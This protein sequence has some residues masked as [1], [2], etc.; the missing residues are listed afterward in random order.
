MYV[1]I[2]ELDTKKDNQ[3]VG[4]AEITIFNR[5]SVIFFEKLTKKQEI[6]RSPVSSFLYFLISSFLIYCARNSCST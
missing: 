2:D 1:V 3:V 4:C 6:T 5:V